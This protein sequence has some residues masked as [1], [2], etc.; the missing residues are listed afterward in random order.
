MVND[1]DGQSGRRSAKYWRDKAEEARVLA[2][3]MSE[4]GGKATMEKIALLYDEMAAGAEL[5]DG[6]IRK[7]R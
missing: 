5:R 2:A 1:G 3:Q 6:P 7:P 4:R